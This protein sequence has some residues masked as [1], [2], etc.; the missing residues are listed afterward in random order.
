MVNPE[1]KELGLTPKRMKPYGQNTAIT[2]KENERR[3]KSHAYQGAEL[4]QC[5]PLDP[6]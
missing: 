3:T 6:K 1:T 5:Y 2:T 4:S